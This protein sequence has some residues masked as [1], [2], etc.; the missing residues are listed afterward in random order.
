MRLCGSFVLS[1][2]LANYRHHSFMR[3]R[4]GDRITPD[5][6]AGARALGALSLTGL[7]VLVGCGSS[8]D[9]DRQLDTVASWTATA[10]LAAAEHRSGAITT[11]YARQLDDEAR[12]ALADAHRALSSS[13]HDANETRRAGAALD[14]LRLAIQLLDTETSR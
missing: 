11:T 10:R 8:K 1:D 13:E 3:M 12:H 14:S 7:L 6:R 4:V 2:E 5:V 9:L